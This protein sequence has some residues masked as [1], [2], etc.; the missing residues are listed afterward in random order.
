MMLKRFN[1]NEVITEEQES[2]VIDLFKEVRST[3]GFLVNLNSIDRIRLAKLSRGRVDF[4]DTSLVEAK[5]NPKHIPGYFTLEEFIANVELMESLQRIRAEAQSLT[6]RIDDTILLVGTETYRKARLF[7]N[8]LKAAG[9]AGEEDAERIAKA[10]SYHF[11][12]QGPSKDSDNNDNVNGN[13]NGTG[14]GGQGQEEMVLLN[15]QKVYG[16]HT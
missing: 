4:V 8:S 1:D 2:Q 5:A 3:L 13:G 11:K 14:N 9:K 10:L 7:Y 6:E 15:D 12:G 16:A